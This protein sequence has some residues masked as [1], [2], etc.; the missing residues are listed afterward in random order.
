M[1]GAIGSIM[2]NSGALTALNGLASAQSMNNMLEGELSS[3]LKINSPADNPSGF[4][5]A[6]GFTSQINGIAQASSNANVG[7]SLL[8]TAQ[9]AV[10]QQLNVAQ[11]LNSIAVQAANGTQTPQEAQALQGVVSQLTGQISTIAS[12]TQFN[13][14][15]LLDGTFTGVQFQVGANEGQTLSLSIGNTAANTIGM[16]TLDA[17][18]GATPLYSASSPSATVSAAGAGKFIAGS[19]TI[20]GSNGSAAVAVT[21]NESAA[22]IASTINAQTN[23]TNVQAQAFTQMTVTLGAGSSGYDFTLSNGTDTSTT[24]AVAISASS[25]SGVVSAIN[26]HSSQTGITAK[27]DTT[28]TKVVLTQSDGKNIAI[29]GVTHGTYAAG[30]QT[31]SSAGGITAQG[32]VSFQSD[33]GF[34]VT[35]ASD[36]GLQSQSNLKAL[37]TINVST[38]AGANA[39]INI[40]KYAIEGLNNLGGQLGATQQ[41]MQATLNNLTS[42]DSNLQNGLS[43]V[44]DANIP[45]VSQKLT[46]SQIQA[47][48]GISALKSSTQLQQAYQKLLP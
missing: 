47:Q 34:N 22:S 37:S 5:T 11:K 30:G 8:Q 9:G 43:T 2:S 44:Q 32:K 24:N 39:A 36:I 28:G 38:V 3:G 27:L 23:K 10:Q 31:A 29:S 13:N 18:A 7:I 1:S 20:N 45:E 21:A 4:I 15:S 26:D 6:E 41:R 42:T 48:A 16:N 33:K 35:N 19:M 25:A 40:V 46:Q 17:S 12:Q 14:I